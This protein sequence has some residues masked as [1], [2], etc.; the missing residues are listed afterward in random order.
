MEIKVGKRFIL[1]QKLGHGSFGEIFLGTDS[2]NNEP[3]AIKLEPQN[4]SHP[5]LKRENKIYSALKGVGN[6]IILI[7]KLIF[8]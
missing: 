2:K 7:V 1:G 6:A 3:V 5:Q 4:C 8:N